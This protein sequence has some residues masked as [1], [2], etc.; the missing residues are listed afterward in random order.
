MG[1]GWAWP[2][3]PVLEVKVAV[4][5]QGMLLAAEDE[6]GVDVLLSLLDELDLGTEVADSKVRKM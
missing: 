6:T 3:D 4:T 1:G 5:V 2:S